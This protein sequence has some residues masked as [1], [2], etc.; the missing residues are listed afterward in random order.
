MSRS[1][2]TERGNDVRFA[3]SAVAAASG[4]TL[5]GLTF[6]GQPAVYLRQAE[7]QWNALMDRP[8]ADQSMIAEADQLATPAAD[9]SPAA[10]AN[11]LL[12][13]ETSRPAVRSDAG[14]SE[15]AAS[16]R[17]AEERAA[18]LQQE[19]ARLQQEL[20]AKQQPPAPEPSPAPPK[21]VGA[22]SPKV[23]PAAPPKTVS[24]AP[25]NAVP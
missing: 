22:V 20:A 1:R 8:A 5:L 23:A 6:Y 16:Q 9:P 24:A 18:R 19:V 4:L 25:A 7:E 14:D 12:A 2:E 11:R 13:A 21:V 15:R 17:A 3:I 10:N